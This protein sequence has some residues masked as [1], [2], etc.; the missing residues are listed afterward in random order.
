MT[1][2]KCGSR[3]VRVTDSRP[4][5]EGSSVRR[6]RAC[7]TCEYRWLTFEVDA[8]QLPEERRNLSRARREKP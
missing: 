1:C 3:Q 5:D 2:P 4:V 6:K 7:R 8:D